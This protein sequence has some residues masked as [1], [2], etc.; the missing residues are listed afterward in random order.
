MKL[1]LNIFLCFLFVSSTQAGDF[2][3]KSRLYIDADAIGPYYQK[4]S[5]EQTSIK[6]NIEI[7][8]IK[9]S[10]KYKFTSNISSKVQVE[11][12]K[13]EKDDYKNEFSLKDIFIKLKT[14]KSSLI[15]G[16][17][18]EAMGHE[19]LMGSSD[20]P[21][22][23]RSLVSSIFSP[24]RNTGIMFNTDFKH[25][26]FH[27]G[28]FQLKDDDIESGSSVTSRLT[29]G[30]SLL[31][32]ENIFH[33]G[34][35]YSYRDLDDSL[36]QIKNRGEVNSAD[37]IIRSSRFYAKDQNIIQAEIGTIYKNIWFM[38]ELYSTQIEQTNGRS[39]QYQ[40]FYL[41]TSGLLSKN[42]FDSASSYKYKNGEFKPTNREAG[43]IEWVIR[44]SGVSVRDYAIGS[45]A[46][47]LLLGINYYL[48]QDTSFMF[49][50][51]KPSISGNVVNT[52]QTGQ[53][54]SM[55]FKYLF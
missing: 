19:E 40:G 45:E 10:I 54:I 41:Q 14:G 49:D 13:E 17:F 7:G 44:Y 8:S 53:A 43:N 11:F 12:K 37:N 18:K 9:S 31:N 15:L 30:L 5:D 34:A 55:R 1:I 51:L 46:S 36:F 16:R 28:A 20:L 26:T 39:W 27:I 3:I 6:N 22:I 25:S 4:N 2:K 23:E 38:A 32:H 42:P 52:N 50:Y 29:H 35:S 33:L 21:T 24:G 48:N 47:S